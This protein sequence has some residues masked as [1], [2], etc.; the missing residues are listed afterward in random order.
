MRVY[1]GVARVINAATSKLQSDVAPSMRMA[2]F[3]ES[4]IA[5]N[6]MPNPPVLARAPIPISL[7][8]TTFRI[9]VKDAA[10]TV[11]EA[12]PGAGT[13][14]SGHHRPGVRVIHRS[15]AAT[16][17]QGRGLQRACC[18]GIHHRVFCK[19]K[20]LGFSRA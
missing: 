11:P 12:S 18:R 13:R 3:S 2:F 16:G 15:L 4:A 17:G 8:S 6:A 20:N 1:T 10:A 7:N 5:F 14:S 19:Y 9:A